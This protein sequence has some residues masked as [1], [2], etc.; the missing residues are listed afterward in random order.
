MQNGKIKDSQISASSEWNHHHGANNARLYFR[1]HSGRTGAWSAKVN[2]VNQWLQVDFQTP[3][4]VLA[5]SLQGRE[6]CCNQ[7]VRSYTVSWSNDGRTFYPYKHH[8][9]IKVCPRY[10][11]LF[12]HAVML[13]YCSYKI[14]YTIGKML[15]TYEVN[16][17]GIHGQQ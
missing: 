4:L 17:S 10:C 5:I 14:Y 6:D 13:L 2:D 1:S 12:R 11:H 3:S 16:I 7:F 9:Q 15:L 8:G